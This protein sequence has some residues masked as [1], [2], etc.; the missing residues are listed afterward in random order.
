VVQTLKDKAC[1]AGIGN[2]EF[3][4][5]SGRSEQHLAL[6]T[7]V[8]ACQD[9]GINPNEIDGIVRYAMDNNRS[10][11]LARNLGIKNLR[12]FPEVALGGGAC[13]GVV[14]M[15]AM[16]VALG[17]ANYVVAFRALN[18]RSGFGTPRY[19]QLGGFTSIGGHMQYIMPY[20]LLSPASQV[21]VVTRRYMHLYGAKSTDLAEVAVAFRRHANTNPNA[22]MHGRPM[23]IEDHQKSRM[24]AD[25][26]RM[27]DCC[28]ETDGAVA[29]LVT[30]PERAKNLKQK[31]VFIMAAEEGT[32]SQ[33]EA[34][35]P[36]QRENIALVD[37]QFH[38]AKHLWKEAGIGPKDID[39]VQ[40]YDAFSPLVL[41]Q[42][43]AFGFCK[44]G[45]GADF[46]KGQALAIDGRLPSCTSGGCLSEGY[47]HGMNHVA[48]GV[49]QIRGTS[50]CQVPNCKHVLVTAASNNPSSA[51]ILRADY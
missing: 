47:I 23:T 32:G 4:K 50:L 35:T 36:Y 17:K 19:G 10:E 51:M 45:E 28:L 20:G 21:A 49:R 1:I 6:E 27:F 33:C 12:F 9:A 5:S 40:W 41:M 31:R 18:E 11:D 48:E 22:M 13:C 37:E 44:V 38:I 42:L 26:L 43:E 29:V 30:T 16:A 14:Q 39:C 3:S 24:I 15:A 46:V 7:I 34:M 2:T 25:P 8:A